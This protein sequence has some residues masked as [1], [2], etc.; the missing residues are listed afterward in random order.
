MRIHLKIKIKSLAAE[1]R[2]IRREELRRKPGDIRTGLYLHR[3]NVVR[4]EQ[5]LALLAYGFLRGRDYTAIETA[6]MT[7]PDWSKL[8]P[9]V[10][11][12]ADEKERAG[13]GERFKAF[14]EVGETAHKAAHKAKQAAQKA[15][16]AK[17]AAKPLQA[18][19]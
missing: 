8:G 5:R 7:Q 19:E 4:R 18:A 17:R 3:I 2:I 12:F 16:K 14:R 13:V 11:R 9:M 1:S 15:A 10:E 6:P